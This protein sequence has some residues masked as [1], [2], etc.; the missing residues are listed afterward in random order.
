MTPPPIGSCKFDLDTPT[1][2]ID[3]DILEA[4]IQKMHSFMN[5][6]GKLWRPHQKCHKTPIIAHK[7]IK[8]GAIGVTCA[9]VSEA[10][11]MADAGIKD[12][13]IANMIVGKPKW[14]RLADLCNIADPIVACDHYAQVAPLSEICKSKNVQC[15]VIIELNIGMDRVGI[16]PGRDTL[17]LA[18]AI[19]KLEGLKLSGIMGYEGHLLAI[20]DQDEKRSK[21]NDAMSVLVQ[22]R[23]MILNE[24]LNC[25]IVSAGGTGSYQMTSDCPGITELQAGG[26]IFADPLYQEQ[27]HLRGLDY[28]LS[29]LATVVSRPT[30][31]RAIIDCG[32]KTH[33]P[34]FQAPL[35]KNIPGA[36]VVQTSAEHCELSLEEKAQDLKI[37]DK[38]EIIPGYADFSTVL[39]NEFHA[40]RNDQ[41]EAIW[42]I[43][44][45]GKLQ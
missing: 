29:L 21:I 45:R 22:N 17:D 10:E 7:Q 43:L 36:T 41:L 15:R 39:H 42:P 28:S 4:N 35:V 24:N 3:L 33:H 6:R 37:G 23:D 25:D 27:C 16:R 14:E 1:L 18:K 34:D 26:G 31:T 44:G 11:V 5:E 40:F 38:I 19:S 12:I 13:L 30:R 8:E 20:E 2:C 9:K 32:R